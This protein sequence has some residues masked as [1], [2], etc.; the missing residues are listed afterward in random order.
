MNSFKNICVFCGA[1]LGQGSVYQ[2]VAQALGAELNRRRIGLIY[3]GG[4][5]GLMGTIA[6]AVLAGGGAVTGVIPGP[7]KTK[8]LSGEVLGDL[9]TVRT[10][11]E[12]KATMTQLADGF[13]AIP[14]GFG[15]LDELF[16]A[17]T[18][19]QLGIHNKPIG[20]LNVNG[21]FTPLLQWIEHALAEGFVRPQHRN[22]IVVADEPAILL[23]LMI[24][25]EPPPALT[26]WLDLN[27]A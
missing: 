15:T 12:R 1:S 14:G 25:Y 21:Y 7:L 5:V 26:K 24:A 10:M 22:L 27:E 4:G 3:G 23:D 13:I 8:E 6:R 9:I 18:W 2:D 11:H 16:E 17:L 20:L 19:G